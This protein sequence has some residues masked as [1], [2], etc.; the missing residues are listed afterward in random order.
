MKT[1]SEQWNVVFIRPPRGR[2]NRALKRWLMEDD[3]DDASVLSY[4]NY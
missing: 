4:V 3:N 1:T 2:Q